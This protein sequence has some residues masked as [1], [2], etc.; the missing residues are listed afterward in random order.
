MTNKGI[1]VLNFGGRLFLVL[2]ISSCATVGP[3]PPPM[4]IYI[5]DSFGGAQGVQ[6]DGT[7]RRLSLEETKGLFCTTGDAMA[8]FSAWC[9][10]AAELPQPAK[11]FG[12]TPKPEPNPLEQTDWPKGLGN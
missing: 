6:E 10:N 2:A 7:R 12:P 5:L 8:Q 3:P 4:P 9:Y 1:K 11:D